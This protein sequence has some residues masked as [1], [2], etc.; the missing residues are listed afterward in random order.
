MP[1]R[2]MIPL[3]D[4]RFGGSPTLALLG[5]ALLIAIFI[6]IAYMTKTALPNHRSAAR[7]ECFRGKQRRAEEKMGTTKHARGNES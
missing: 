1:V 7:G 4:Y 5:L 3:S 2:A 6:V